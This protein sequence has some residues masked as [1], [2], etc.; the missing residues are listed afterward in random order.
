M[1]IAATMTQSLGIRGVDSFA[2]LYFQ[3]GRG[4]TNLIEATFL[5]STLKI[6][7]LFSG[8]LCGRLSDVFGRKKTVAVLV[9]FEGVSLYLLTIVPTNILIAP[10]LIFGFSTF[11]LLGTIDAFLAD[12]TPWEYMTAV[13]GL[14]F[15]LS[16]F[17]QVIITP[18]FGLIVDY[19][20]SFDLGF[21]MLSAIAFSGLPILY[22]VKTKRESIS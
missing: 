4:I 20:K 11:G 21:V 1:L 13:F 12:I 8:P 17:N 16:F 15:T 2:I 19:S 6:A 10:C 9:V 14:H 22:K 18:I 5:F 7:G 3:M